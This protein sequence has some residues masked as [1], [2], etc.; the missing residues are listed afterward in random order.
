MAEK[1][2]DNNFFQPPSRKKNITA[3]VIGILHIK[4]KE[5]IFFLN[6]SV[7]YVT[8]HIRQYSK[9]FLYVKHGWMLKSAQKKNRKR[10]TGRRR[11]TKRTQKIGSFH[12]L[13]IERVASYI[14]LSLFFYYV[15][16]LQYTYIYIYLGLN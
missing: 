10:K 7:V 16:F 9:W 6:E 4:V 13:E 12:I 5:N 1:V 3:N 14:P 15:V 2:C 8:V 11:R